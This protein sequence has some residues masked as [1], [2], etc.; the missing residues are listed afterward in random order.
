MQEQQ[1]EQQQQQVLRQ[2]PRH[3]LQERVFFIKKQ[4]RIEYTPP[5][6][7]RP[8]RLQLQSLSPCRTASSA[9]LPFPTGLEVK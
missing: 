6:L 2:Q 5:V 9:F 4:A 3:E 8:I 7:C 1:L